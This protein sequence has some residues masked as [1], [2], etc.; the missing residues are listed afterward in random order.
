MGTNILLF[1]SDFLYLFDSNSFSKML[2]LVC[3]TVINKKNHCKFLFPVCVSIACVFIVCDEHFYSVLHVLSLFLI[4]CVCV[5]AC[6]R[7]C[8]CMCVYVRFFV[9]NLFY[10]PSTL[11]L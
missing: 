4:L 11:S 9:F 10:F 6:V 5:R 7:A 2:E 1:I 8:V 3:S